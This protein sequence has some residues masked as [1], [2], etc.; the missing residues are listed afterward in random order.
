MSNTPV[1]TIRI[2]DVLWAKVQKKAAKEHTTASAVIIR[3]LLHY[4]AE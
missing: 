1:R 4:L 2:P 3:L